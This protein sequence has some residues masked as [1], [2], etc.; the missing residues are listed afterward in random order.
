MK[1][2]NIF[3]MLVAICGFMQALITIA[4]PGG[5]SAGGG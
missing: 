1:K 3:K 4:G 5:G 2:S